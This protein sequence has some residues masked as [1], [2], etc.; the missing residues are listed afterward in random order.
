MVVRPNDLL[1]RAYSSLPTRM[2]VLLEKLDDGRE[3][4]LARQI[5]AP[6]MAGHAGADARERLRERD[7]TA[8]LHFVAD[9]APARVITILLAAPRVATGRLQVA[10]R[11]R[12]DPDIG[13]RRRES[14]AIEFVRAQPDSKSSDRLDPRTE[15]DCG[16]RCGGSR[17]SARR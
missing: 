17:V 4:F 15:I 1:S 3:H 8:V 10:A 6:Q 16:A 7:E 14:P 9:L 5:L 11:I 12:A 2:S 13:P